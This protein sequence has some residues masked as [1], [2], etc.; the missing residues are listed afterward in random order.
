MVMNFLQLFKMDLRAYCFPL[1]QGLCFYALGISAFLTTFQGDV[2]VY[3]IHLFNMMMMI[4][5]GLMITSPLFQGEYKSGILI[6]NLINHRNFAEGIVLSKFLMLMIGF[7]A[8]VLLMHLI[9]GFEVML[10]LVF[11]TGLISLSLFTSSLLVHVRGGLIGVIITLPL[12]LPLV[13]LMLLNVDGNIPAIR[14]FTALML[15]QVLLLFLITPRILK[16]A[17]DVS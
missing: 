2:P 8:P 11:L 7:A 13:W 10:Y 14:L 15:F 6:Q 9:I 12:M 1:L 4:L 5:A 17:Y 16:K 3:I